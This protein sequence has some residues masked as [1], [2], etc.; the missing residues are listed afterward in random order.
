MINFH[1]SL[2]TIAT[3]NIYKHKGSNFK[4]SIKF[5]KENLLTEFT[6]FKTEQ[7]LEK[8]YSWSN[9]SIYIFEPG[10]FQYIPQNKKTD[11]SKNLFPRLLKLKKK[12]SVFPS[13]GYFQDIG[14]LDSL[15]KA[16]NVKF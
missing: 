12:I 3:V 10:I 1:K 13:S 7:I 11:F 9:G 16:N 2:K 6:E 4:S 5:S 8:G 15:E 14:T